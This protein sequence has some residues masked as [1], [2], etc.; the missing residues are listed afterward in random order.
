MK[1]LFII[2]LTLSALTTSAQTQKPKAIFPSRYKEVV[3]S[4]TFKKREDLQKYLKSHNVE[5]LS[6]SSK[7]IVGIESKVWFI[8][9]TFIDKYYTIERQKLS[10]ICGQ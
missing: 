3:D 7:Q 4:S 10:E 8:T 6:Q 5:I 9:I 2:A 1:A